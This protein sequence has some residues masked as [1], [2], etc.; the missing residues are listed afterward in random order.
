M[1][2]N[3][4]VVMGVVVMMVETFVRMHIHSRNHMHTHARQQFIVHLL[5]D[6]LFSET[7]R[8]FRVLAL[9]AGG[10][11]GIECVRE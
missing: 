9:Q 4:S 1:C 5:F 3:M 11:G 7:F 6:F 2:D 8:Q 10:G